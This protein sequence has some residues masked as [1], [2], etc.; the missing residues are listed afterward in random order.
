MQSEAVKLIAKESFY[1]DRVPNELAKRT[2]A[3]VMS[4][5]IMVNGTPAAKDY[6]GLID[7]IVNAFA[8]AR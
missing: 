4:V 8:A 1:S 5:P 3:R 6:I 7:T 2:G